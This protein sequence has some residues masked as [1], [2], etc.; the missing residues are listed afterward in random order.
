M[1][2]RRFLQLALLIVPAFVFAQSNPPAGSVNYMLVGTYTEGKSE[3]IYVYKFNSSIGTYEYVNK[4]TGIK[5]P[6][7]L[8]V[9]PNHKFVYAVN[10]LHNNNNG[11]AIT[12]YRFDAGSGALVKLNDQL[13]GGDDPCYVTVD[14]TGKWVIV[15]NYSSGS[16]SV[17]PVQKDG[18]LGKAVT[19]IFHHGNSVNKDRQEKAHVHSTVLSGDNNWLFVPDLG[20]DKVMIYKFNSTNGSL[21]EATP[22][23]VASAPGAGP[24]HFVFSENGK[25]AYLI[26]EMSGAVSVFNYDGKGHLKMIQTLSSHPKDFAG[27]KGSADI[28]IS[29]DGKFLYASNRGD[30]NSIAIYS[31][32]PTNGQLSSVGFQSTIGKTPRNFSLDPTGKYLLVA[33]QATDN[34]IVFKRDKTTGKLSETGKP[35]E[36]P[37]PVCIK[38]IPAK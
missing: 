33:N 1:I 7:Y 25:F 5:N 29:P 28:H 20:M 22:S 2:R 13:S 38:W 31:I 3:G 35:L 32:N 10:E 30:A 34:I 23:F 12:A 4:A 36:V 27:N 24:R 14:K 9:S 19:N 26:Q 18:S 15:G 8:A 6:S 17:L 21:K 11:G 16:L 37:T